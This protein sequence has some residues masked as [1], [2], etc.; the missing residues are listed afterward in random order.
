MHICWFTFDSYFSQNDIRLAQTDSQEIPVSRGL[1]PAMGSH[2]G[3]TKKA[4]FGPII[5]VVPLLCNTYRWR[6]RYFYIL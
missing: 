5:Q 1:H 3:F 2:T 6:E 4:T